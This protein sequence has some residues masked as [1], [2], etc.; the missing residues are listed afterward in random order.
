MR[1]KSI[2]L[3]LLL[4]ALGSTCWAEDLI[5]TGG[6][7][8]GLVVQLGCGDVTDMLALSIHEAYLVQG[9]DTDPAQ[10]AAARQKIRE[11]GTYGRVTASVFDGK[12]LPYLDNT[13]YLLIADADTF[14]DHA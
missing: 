7:C 9:L 4:Y 13:V 10:V 12:S 11:A 3:P 14:V 1:A 6:V 2:I 8:G 5:R